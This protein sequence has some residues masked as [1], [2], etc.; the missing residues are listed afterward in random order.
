MK[1]AYSS[2]KSVKEKKIITLA[3]IHCPLSLIVKQGLGKTQPL[4]RNQ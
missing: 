2:L 1:K 4:E 3:L